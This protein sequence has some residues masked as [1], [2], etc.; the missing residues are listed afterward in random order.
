M[1]INFDQQKW[2][3]SQSPMTVVGFGTVGRMHCR[4]RRAD[5]RR[6]R[7]RLRRLYWQWQRSK[8][9]INHCGGGPGFR[10]LMLFAVWLGLGV[11]LGESS[12]PAATLTS[13]R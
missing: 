5:E 10:Y 9:R 8:E 13:A 12:Y 4:S 11:G 6:G 2:A 7:R 1:G 3:S